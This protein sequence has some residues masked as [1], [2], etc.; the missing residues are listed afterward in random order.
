MST[1]HSSSTA[2]EI[3]YSFWLVFGGDGTMRFSRSQPSSGRGE[4]AISCLARLPRSLFRTPEL[5]ATITVD[6]AN[7]GDI[8]IDVAAA[9]EALREVVGVDIDLQIRRP[10]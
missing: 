9:A 5:K 10:E 7:V 2:T 1:K 6:A 3:N 4:R 8:Q